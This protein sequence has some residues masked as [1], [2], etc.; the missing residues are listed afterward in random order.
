MPY[1]YV[2][3]NWR[4]NGRDLF[5]PTSSQSLPGLTRQSMMPLNDGSLLGLYRYDLVRRISEHRGGTVRGFTKRYGLKMLVYFEQFD[6]PRLAL[7]REKNI[8]HWPVLGS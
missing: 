5:A 8:K 4:F 1:E 3:R 7:Q 6:A 2:R